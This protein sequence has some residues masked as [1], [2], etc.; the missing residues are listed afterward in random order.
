MTEIAGDKSRRVYDDE[1]EVDDRWD[2]RDPAPAN[3]V[4][5]PF[6]VMAEP[7]RRRIV[8]ILASG[9]HSSGQVAEVVGRE[10]RLSRTAV[11]KHLRIL[12]DCGF[13]EVRPQWQWRLYRLVP[14]AVERLE[15]EVAE[16]RMKIELSDVHGD[17]LAPMPPLRR[18][19]PG[20]IIRAGRRGRQAR[21]LRGTDP[22]EVF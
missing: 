7:V 15:S 11:S 12:R 21:I 20:R 16:L 8:D 19:G 3:R 17:P 18:R 2:G 4:M 6:A 9:E 13:V 14:Y 22:E 10:Y 5:D 1:S